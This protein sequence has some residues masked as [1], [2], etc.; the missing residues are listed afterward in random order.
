MAGHDNPVQVRDADRDSGAR[1]PCQSGRKTEE[2]P[3]L[4]L[5][6]GAVS[7][8]MQVYRRD[9]LAYASFR[10]NTPPVS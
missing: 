7:N 9:A 5:L 1:Q 4:L 10:Q 6:T 3:F 2:A 8:L